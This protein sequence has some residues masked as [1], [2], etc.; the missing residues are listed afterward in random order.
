M[1]L[2]N[3][4]HNHRQSTVTRLVYQ[5][6]NNQRIGHKEAYPNKQWQ[7]QQKKRKTE[8]PFNSHHY[9]IWQQLTEYRGKLPSLANIFYNL[10][11]QVKC[12]DNL[13]YT[14]TPMTN[15]NTPSKANGI[16]SILL[17]TAL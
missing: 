7:Q 1:W 2:E 16:R 4:A 15:A 8:S 3:A 14:L 5:S 13:K 17:C 12:I 6:P 9:A 11:L 10:M